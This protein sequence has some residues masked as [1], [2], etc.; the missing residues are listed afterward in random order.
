MITAEL[1][2]PLGM[3]VFDMANPRN[4]FD[5]KQQKTDENGTPMWTVQCLLRQENARAFETIR[6]NVPSKQDPNEVLTPLA[7]VSF[8]NLRVMTGDNNG[9]TWVSFSADRI[10]TA[11]AAPKAD[12]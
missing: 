1:T 11:A 2:K 3:L 7:P 6:V 9:R 12:K 4:D 8:E 5:T 10:N